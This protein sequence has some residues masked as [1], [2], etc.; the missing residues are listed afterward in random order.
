MPPQSPTAFAQ[1]GV[2]LDSKPGAK[3]A[4]ANPE[5]HRTVQGGDQGHAQTPAPMTGEMT[6]QVPILKAGPPVVRLTAP[7]VPTVGRKGGG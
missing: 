4:A 5:V 1:F 2:S 3:N 6:G 7:A